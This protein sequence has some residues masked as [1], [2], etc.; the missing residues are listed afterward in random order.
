MYWRPLWLI[1][2]WL[3]VAAVILLSLIKLPVSLPHAQGDKSG[4]VLAYLVLMF[5]FAQLYAARARRVAIAI[6]LL[7]LGCGLE[8]VQHAVGRDFEYADMLADGLG[9]SLGWLAAP[10]RT[11]HVLSRVERCFLGRQRG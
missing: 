8:V 6:A 2:G 4:H 11:P 3:L 1:V 7:V 5:W 9:I 10:P